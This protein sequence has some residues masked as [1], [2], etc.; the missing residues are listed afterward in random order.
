[1]ARSLGLQTT[2]EGV[3]H[4]AQAVALQSLGCDNVQGFH[5]GYPESAQA[6]TERWLGRSTIV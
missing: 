1:M 2:A 4:A 6:F 5:F 3:E